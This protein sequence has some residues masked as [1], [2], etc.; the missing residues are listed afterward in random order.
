MGLLI[1][2]PDVDDHDVADGGAGDQAWETGS[3]AA[4]SPRKARAA[5]RAL[6]E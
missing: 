3:S 6:G 5:S 4:G 1:P 2:L